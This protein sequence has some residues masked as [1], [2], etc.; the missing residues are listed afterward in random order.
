[1]STRTPRGTRSRVRTE[2]ER[3]RHQDQKEEAA[4]EKERVPIGVAEPEFEE[5]RCAHQAKIGNFEKAR[6]PLDKDIEAEERR[7]KK[8]EEQFEETLPGSVQSC[9]ADLRLLQGVAKGTPEVCH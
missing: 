9:T 5:A 1:V 6:A 2:Q 4:R 8:R 7:W 3:H